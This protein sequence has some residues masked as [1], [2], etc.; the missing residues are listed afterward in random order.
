MRKVQHLSPS[1]LSTWLKN[2]DEFYLQ[3]LAHDRPPRIPQNQPMAIGSAFDAYAKSYLVE[4][5]FGSNADPKYSFDALFESQVE[6]QNRDWA[7]EHGR[8]VFEQY[9]QSGALADLFTELKSAQGQ[10]RFEFEVKGAVSGY[11]EGATRTIGSVVL[12]G[13]PDVAFVNKAGVMIVIDWKVNG[14]CSKNPP[15]PCR[16][17]FGCVRPARATTG[18]TRAATR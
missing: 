11:R 6:R 9:Q 14:Y 1:S 13:K 18:C 12:L 4:R 5:L 7:R 3:Y 2:Q 17:M 15:S 8:Y 10:P 16:A